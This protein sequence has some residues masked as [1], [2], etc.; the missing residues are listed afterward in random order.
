VTIIFLFHES[1]SVTKSNESSNIGNFNSSKSSRYRL[2]PTK[3][4]SQTLGSDLYRINDLYA[5]GD[6]QPN[7]E[8]SAL[9]AR[10]NP[11][12]ALCKLNLNLHPCPRLL[13]NDK[14]Y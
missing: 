2:Q 10:N 5:G 9:H 12:H 14:S 4:S 7:A 3:P 6:P 8:S 13:E 1:K 11:G